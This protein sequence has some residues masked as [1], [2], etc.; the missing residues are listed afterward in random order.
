VEGLLAQ[1]QRRSD[2]AIEHFRQA[3]ATDPSLREARDALAKALVEN[4]RWQEAVEVLGSLTKHDPQ[5]FLGAYLYALA[6]YHVK[7]PREAEPEA[8]RA[9]SLGPGSSDA[10]ALLGDILAQEGREAEA[11][12]AHQRA[13]DLD[14]GNREE[15]RKKDQ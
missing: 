2:F 8:R 14:S 1:D 7:T 10:Y 11:R 15:V 13:R 4:R 9:V 5:S 12:A 6:L 3:A